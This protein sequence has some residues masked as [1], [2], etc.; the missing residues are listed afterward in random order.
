MASRGRDKDIYDRR[1]RQDVSINKEVFQLIFRMGVGSLASGGLPQSGQEFR[2]G[3]FD[4]EVDRE[5][6][7]EE[8][9]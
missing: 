4:T 6:S 9:V 3:S 1:G 5:V 2:I 8:Y 7:Y